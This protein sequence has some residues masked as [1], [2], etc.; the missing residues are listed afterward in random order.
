LVCFLTNRPPA[1]QPSSLPYSPTT[2]SGSL[3]RTSSR[4]CT[5]VS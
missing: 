1:Q 2:S 4:R 5:V 3:T